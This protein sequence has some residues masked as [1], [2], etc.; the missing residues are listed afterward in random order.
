MFGP[1]LSVDDAG[2]KWPSIGI[3]LKEIVPRLQVK[4]GTY[5]ETPGAERDIPESQEVN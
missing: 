2:A 1:G 5:I 4:V 3:L